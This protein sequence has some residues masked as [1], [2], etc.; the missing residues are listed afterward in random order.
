VDHGRVVG[1][2]TDKGVVF[3]GHLVLATGGGSDRLLGEV[4]VHLPLR[5]LTAS[6]VEA[7][8][9][10][11]G[12]RWPLVLATDP[13]VALRGTAGGLCLGAT[14]P[15]VALDP[16]LDAWAASLVPG[17]DDAR[18]EQAWQGT[19]AGTPD[20]LPWVGPCPGLDGLVLA[21]GFEAGA[22]SHASCAGRLV[23]Q[24]LGGRAAGT[25]AQALDPRR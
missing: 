13:A 12:A 23:A 9:L 2:R 10:T 16:P 21:L 6:V 4:G 14:T 15:A 22:A 7:C 20:G 5:A 25:I 18:F 3:A 11:G 19:L 1:V 24:W 8:E 17:L